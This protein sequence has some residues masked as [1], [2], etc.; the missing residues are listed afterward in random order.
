MQPYT[1]TYINQSQQTVHTMIQEVILWEMI[2]VDLAM[3]EKTNTETLERKN[4]YKTAR[5]TFARP[6]IAGAQRWWADQ[7]QIK[8]LQEIGELL[9][10]AYQLRDDLID[11]LEIEKDKP[12]FMDIQ[13]GQ[14][15]L[16]TDYIYNHPNKHYTNILSDHMGQ[17][18][19]SK[20]IELLKNMYQESWAIDFAKQKI[21]AYINDATTTLEKI[22]F[23]NQQSKQYINQLITK[24]MIP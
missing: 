8:L 9:W 15:T 14:Q 3:G 16:I 12:T 23:E 17:K 22:T 7:Q 4:L 20:Q 5:Y 13:E 21:A 1:N 10:L 6:L 18:L 11:I 19:S 2:D 24:L